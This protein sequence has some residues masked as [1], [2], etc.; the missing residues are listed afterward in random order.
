MAP[1]KIRR[2]IGH[3]KDQTSISLAKVGSSSSVSDLEVAIVKATRHEEYPAEERHI[4]EILS[5]TSYSRAHISAC[6]KTLS[7]RLNKTRNWTVALKTLMLIQRL[8]S[9]GDPAYEQEIFFSTRRGTRILNMSDFRDTSQSNSW[10]FSAFVRTYAL[11]LD[12]RLEY[13]ME[14][15]YGGRRSM[16]GY[17]DED[18]ED[19]EDPSVVRSIPIAELKNE[20][21]FS[22][23]LHLQQLLDRFLGCR[24][25]GSAKGNRVVIVALHAIV[26][27]SFQIYYDITEILGVLIDR[28]MELDIS[29]SIKIYNIFCRERKQFDDLENFY[30]WCKSIGIARSY[31]Y[32]EIE[33]ITQKKLDLIDEFIRDKSA[34]EQGKKVSDES[35]FVKETDSCEEEE[36]MN[37]VKSLPEPEPV[38]KEEPEPEK[39]EEVD[40]SKAL[41]VEPKGDLL[42]L[43][44]DAMSSQDYG[45]KLALALFDGYAPAAVGTP[46]SGPGWEAFMDDADWESALV[47]SASNL[48]KQ[49]ATLG[50]GFDIL[51]LDSMYQQG[52]T[53]AAMASSGYAASGSTSSFAFGSSGRPAMLA[54]P[55]PPSSKNI[56]NTVVDPFSASLTVEP[57]SYVQMSD[58]EKKQRFLVEEQAMWDQYRRDGLRG[59]SSMSKVHSYP[60]SPG[61]T[62]WHGY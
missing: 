45:D 58:I 43:A 57:P 40:N 21:L 54:L 11:Y 22:K 15:R 46:S 50:G 14:G 37:A 34:L 29:D 52:N 25:I 9:E 53:M 13:M 6:V 26:K 51:L 60:Y 12:E 59:Y 18:H 10:D 32:P 2:A 1:S 27:E 28:F 35:G 39:E 49:R 4:Q 41:V 47:Q 55:A 44:E 38:E 7:K 36:D 3:V 24:P 48:T 56:G 17:N 16:Y 62:P 33:K 31:D 19:N 30:S 5:L 23:L 8:L 42:D 20:H 61:Y